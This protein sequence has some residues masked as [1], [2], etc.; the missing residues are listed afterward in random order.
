MITLA[1]EKK[2]K[3]KLVGEIK[4]LQKMISNKNSFIINS[5]TD[6]DNYI[7]KY[8][9]HEMLEKM[10]DRVEKLVNLKININDANK[11][12]I[13][14]IFSISELKSKLKFINS[15]DVKEGYVTRGYLDADT[16][17]Y[18]AQIDENKRNELKKEIQ[19][20]IDRLQDE[21]DVYNHTTHLDLDEKDF[22]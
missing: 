17:K 7:E 11:E 20:E 5:G 4:D 15:L 14:L 21:I 12:I 3:N 10:S 6:V 9:V 19:N 16:S 2:K 13:H 1:K 18:Y 8:N 22:V